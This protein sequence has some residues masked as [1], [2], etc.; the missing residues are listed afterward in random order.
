MARLLPP[1]PHGAP[2]RPRGLRGLHGGLR[3]VGREDPGAFGLWEA[4]G[5]VF[6]GF[7]GGI[8]WIGAHVE[9][10]EVDSEGLG[11]G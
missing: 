3:D 10:S 11:P 8:E 4:F 2:Q 5:P 6:G 9:P 7:Q 1:A